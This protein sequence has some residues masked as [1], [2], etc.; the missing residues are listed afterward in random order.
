MV[1]AE[2]DSM[3]IS[4][5]ILEASKTKTKNKKQTTKKSSLSLSVQPT[6]MFK[7]IFP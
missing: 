5:Q 1:M 4:E 2:G 6:T 3:L 7:N